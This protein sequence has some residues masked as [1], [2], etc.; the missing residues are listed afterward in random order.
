MTQTDATLAQGY[1]IRGVEMSDAAAVTDLYRLCDEAEGATFIFKEEDIVED[2]QRERFDLPADAWIIEAPD[3]LVVGYG[4]VYD[5]D[6]GVEIESDALVHPA[7]RGRGIGGT[8]VALME[9]RAREIVKAQSASAPVKLYNFTTAVDADAARLLRAAGYEVVRHFWHMEG[10]LEDAVD[11]RKPEGVTVRAFVFDTDAPAVHEVMQESFKEHWGNVAAPFNE[12]SSI[13]KRSDF[14]AGLW[15]VAVE[16][17]RIVGAL[18]ALL[19]PDA[20]FVR[21]IG[22]LPQ[23]RHRGI[24]ES[25]LRHAFREFRARGFR[26][27]ALN[28]D[29]TNET[30]ATRLYERVG[31]RVVRQF[32]AYMKELPAR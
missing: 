6:P 28:V 3:G 15:F 30:G 7:H 26:R 29:A 20:G 13:F 14:D 17:S 4:E 9:G 8:L 10:S 5:N 16:D 31:M 18:T 27:A 24:G 25:L 19:Y 23:W 22:V 1:S 12:W 11:L 32:D 21:E 2:W